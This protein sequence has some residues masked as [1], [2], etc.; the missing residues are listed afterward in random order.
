MKKQFSISLLIMI[1][2]LNFL[3]SAPVDR[4]KAI[5]VAQNYLAERYMA[6]GLNV[7]DAFEIKSIDVIHNS[8]DEFAI[9]YV[10]N[11]IPQGFILVSADDRVL[12]VLAYSHEN[13]MNIDNLAP[14]I[15]YWL[16]GYEMQIESAIKNDLKADAKTTMDWARLS[17]D[18]FVVQTPKSNAVVGPLIPF[19]WDQGRFY[20]RMCPEDSEAPSGYDGRVP[21]GC[22][23][24]ATSLVM[25]YHRH[26]EVGTGSHSYNASGYGVQTANYGATTYDWNAMTDE[27]T[28]YNTNVAKLIYHVG[29]AVEMDYAADGSGSQ[30]EYSTSALKN[31]FNYSN[32]ISTKGR[33][34]YPTSSWKS[35]LKQN[36]DLDHPMIYSGSS[37]A[38][39][40]HAFN[41]DGYD[42]ED[43]FHFNWG[44]GGYG[45]GYFIISDLNPVGNEFNSY[46]QAIVNIFPNNPA[47][48]CPSLKTLTASSGS[49]SDGSGSTR[50]GHNLDC[51]WLIAPENAASIVVSFSRLKTELGNDIVTIYD[52]EST[53]D[54]VVGTYS[55]TT[56]PADITINGPKALVRFQT[57]STVDNQG[58]LLNYKANNQTLFCSATKL[59]TAPSG[60]I[61]DGSEDL[62][63][64]NTTY[65]RWLIQPPGATSITLTFSSFDVSPEDEVAIYNRAV[66]P[67]ELIAKYSGTNLP[68]T[69]VLPAGRLGVEFLSDNYSVASGWDA[70]W[71]STGSTAGIQNMD[72]I[73][74]MSIFPNPANSELNIQIA[75]EFLINAN[76]SITD[77]TGKKLLNENISV[78][79]MLNFK[80][81]VSNYSK[82]M[83]FVS[84]KNETGTM[85]LKFIK[86]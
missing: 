48:S 52:G 77:L 30:T 80:L 54:P 35:L 22:V 67:I 42:D 23:A 5:Q 60:D 9:M 83:Y 68:P 76:L 49:I 14:A 32:T 7:P 4:E 6:R 33:W 78:S 41:C 27:L 73:N 84:L 45:N 57:N 70:S 38:S 82:G 40:G 86:Q 2:G 19:I 85:I 66:S 43:F 56:L 69:I 12:P 61:S 47:N 74:Q 65:C 58:F 8:T 55:G 81:D 64:N 63:Y 53:S 21:N 59:I 75:S 18:D 71:T 50:Y 34:S 28:S 10:V 20:N 1:L 44:W 79:E 15:K 29:V 37:Q 11:V 62:N 72:G 46:Q 26:P 16:S 36:L 31:Y 13:F 3:C 25:Y 24:L 17:V 39:G 51:R